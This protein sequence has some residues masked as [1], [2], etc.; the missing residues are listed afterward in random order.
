MPKDNPLA[1]MDPQAI[2]A[3]QAQMLQQGATA[4]PQV[5]GQYVRDDDIT[6]TDPD[7]VGPRGPEPAPVQAADGQL[8]SIAPEEALTMLQEYMRSGGQLGQAQAAGAAETQAAP[9]GGQGIPAEVEAV[10]GEPTTP[11][12]DD[13]DAQSGSGPAQTPQD[14]IAEVADR[15]S[16]GGQEYTVKPGD[17][18]STIA[19]RLLG[20]ASRYRELAQ[21]NGIPNP[22]LIFP[23]MVLQIPA[24]ARRST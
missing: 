9:E 11:G 12:P 18:L 16:G 1:Y 19:Y 21:M 15:Q 8:Q 10:N 4:G 6:V 7:N 13:A 23:G 2:A 14:E 20:D 24:G 17:N 22:D 3:M 5:G